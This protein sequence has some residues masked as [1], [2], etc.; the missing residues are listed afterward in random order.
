M[1]E[2]P[3]SCVHGSPARDPLF[4]GWNIARWVLGGRS[5]APPPALPPQA[6]AAVAASAAADAA[7]ALAAWEAAEEGVQELRYE[8]QQQ[9]GQYGYGVQQY[10]WAVGYEDEEAGEGGE[11]LE[12]EEEEEEE[13]PYDP[14]RPLKLLLSGGA[15]PRVLGV[16]EG[17][18]AAAGAPSLAI[19]SEL[20]TELLP[21]P[22]P[23]P[24]RCH[25]F[26]LLLLQV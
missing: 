19:C 1:E 24:S 6:S 10:P 26:S 22:P 9:Y 17:A 4:A 7:A 16:G 25:C 20:L 23:S 14:Y 2:G 13:G 11:E 21:P 18:A 12:G 5:P 3:S 8:E 15:L